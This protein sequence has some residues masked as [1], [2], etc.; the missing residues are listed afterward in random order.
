MHVRALV[1][2]S[3]AIETEFTGKEGSDP[4]KV[5]VT[6]LVVES[7]SVNVAVLKKDSMM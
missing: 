5:G 3:L 7:D 1:K 2:N 6:K 4:G